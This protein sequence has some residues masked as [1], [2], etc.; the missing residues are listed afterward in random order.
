MPPVPPRLSFLPALLL[1]VLLS[2]SPRADVVILQ[3]GGEVEGEVREQDDQI[4]ITTPTG[5]TLSVPRSDVKEIRRKK[6]PQDELKDRQRNLKT[7]DANATFELA[8]WCRQNGFR[9]EF[10]RYMKETL[11]LE[12]NHPE[13]TKTEYTYTKTYRKLPIHEQ[14]V[15]KLRQEFGPSFKVLHNQHFRIC[16]NSDPEFARFRA[17]LF[18]SVYRSFY[19]FFELKGFPLTTLDDHLEV[20]LFDTRDQFNRYART[21]NPVLES[22]AGFYSPLED[23]VT[24]F[25][26]LN[27]AHY[28]R[29]K[30]LILQAEDE[31]EAQR[32]QLAQTRATQVTLTFSDGKSKTY[33]KSGAM[34]VLA[35]EERRIA[36]ERR[37]LAA[38]YRNENLTTTVH[39]CLHQLAF[40]LG[41]QS[42]QGDNPKWVAEGLATFFETATDGSLAQIG[43]VNADRL[44]LFHAHRDAGRVLSLT[45]LIGQDEVFVVNSETAGLAYAEAWGLV[46]FLMNRRT[47]A[48]L[49]YLQG[50]GSQHVSQP[51]PPEL[52]LAQFVEAMGEDLGQLQKAWLTYMNAL[53]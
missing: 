26:A 33:S 4:E 23:R 45:T 49:K 44:K 10:E 48:F 12:P 47:G 3:H 20:V 36:D 43:K 53:K 7:G 31:V 2:A 18:E 13:A 42:I 25:N 5:A 19:G 28:Q 35:R 37:K 29:L 17:D 22:S 1:G 38:I 16:Y 46:H 50:L 14:A 8:L 34:N 6:L 41:V 40:N 11:R 32:R 24:F 21:R 9:D 15:E 30:A 27:D 52:R 51:L 39:E